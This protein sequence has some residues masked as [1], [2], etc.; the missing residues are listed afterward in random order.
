MNRVTKKKAA[1]GFYGTRWQVFVN[2]QP[3]D[4]FIEKSTPP[5]YGC[6]QM[7]D[8]IDG[9]DCQQVL[10]DVNSVG[11]AMTTIEKLVNLAAAT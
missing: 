2:G 9:E 11:L 1:P 6:P 10:F 5:K 8:V 4:L 3:T 7:Y